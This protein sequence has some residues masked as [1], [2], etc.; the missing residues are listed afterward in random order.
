MNSQ[1]IFITAQGLS[2]CSCDIYIDH[3]YSIRFNVKSN[4]IETRC[5]VVKGFCL[6]LPKLYVFL[7]IHY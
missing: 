7:L 5:C 3:R 4:R 6:D 1:V 2:V